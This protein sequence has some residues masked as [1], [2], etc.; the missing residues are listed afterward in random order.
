MRNHELQRARPHR[1]YGLG[2]VLLTLVLA[3]TAA[4]QPDKDEPVRL[5]ADQ[6]QL[7][8]ATGESVYTGDVRLTQGKTVITGDRLELYTTDDGAIERAVVTGEPATYKGQ[9]EKKKT[10][11]RGEAPR[12]IYYAGSDERIRMTEGAVLWQGKDRL[13]GETVVYRVKED[14]VEADSSEGGE[15]RINITLSPASESE[16]D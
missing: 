2:L 6:A 13:E 1:V 8:N 12:M 3:S 11:V 9:P 10:I 15:D 5:E 7:N 4:A 14:T 16:G